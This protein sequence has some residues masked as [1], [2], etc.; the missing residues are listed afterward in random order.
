MSNDV[1]QVRYDQLEDI[2]N[3]FARKA[4]ETAQLQ[5]RILRDA[6]ALQNGGWMGAG[7]QAFSNE[8]NSVVQPAM[9]RLIQA[10]ETASSTSK[11]IKQIMLAA[12]EEAA[13]PFKGSGNGLVNGLLQAGQ[14]ALNNLLGQ[15]SAGGSISIDGNGASLS[16]TLSIGALKLTAALTMPFNLD[17]I[18]NTIDVAGKA[19]DVAEGFLKA[20]TDPAIV[21]A[22]PK[23]LQEAVESGSTVLK[24]AKS[25]INKAGHLLDVVDLGFAFAQDGYAFGDNS[26]M[27]LGEIGGSLVG[28]WLGAKGGAITGGLIGSA[29][30]IIGTGA[31]VAIG[32]IIGGILGSWKGGDLGK[33]L[34]EKYIIN[35]PPP[36]PSPSPQVVPYYA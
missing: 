30:P 1:V 29:V 6:Q 27:K 22:L 31:G 23:G 9:Q 12:E 36:Q 10:F 16:G 28:G 19:G 8:M 35:P 25:I 2:A 15:I 20:M 34:V 14:N 4:Q 33:D 21:N 3:R 7:S 26:K 32:G 17:Q 18:R 13:R 5:Q 24:G 11:E